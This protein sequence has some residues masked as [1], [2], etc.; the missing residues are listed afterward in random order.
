VE[1]CSLGYPRLAAFMS[2]ETTFGVYRGF[3]YLHSRLLLDRQQEV[4]ALETELDELDEIDAQEEEGR[5]LTNRNYDRKR[6]R[7]NEPGQSLRSRKAILDDIHKKVLE[8]DELLLKCREIQSFPKPSNRDYR[9]V[10]TWMF[11]HRKEMVEKDSSFIRAREDIITFRQGREWSSF[12]GFVE[13]T[14]M[15][16]DC[17]LIRVSTLFISTHSAELYANLSLIQKIFCTQ[18]LRDKTTDKFMFYYSSSRI[19][20]MVGL[21]MMV[22]VLV[23]L[24]IPVVVMYHLTNMDER[25]ETFDA[26]VVLIVFTLL[27]SAAMSLLT[28]A[29]RH[30]L[31]AATATYCAVLVVFISNFGG[32]SLS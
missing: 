5:R 15:R 30:E 11:N 6:P 27:F 9:S 13:S 17:S 23:L 24:A 28:K 14:L 18:E 16:F 31:F 12:D 21:L 32:K 19:E 3:G 26:I 25:N 2:S 8:Y 29:R 1:E 7:K 22:I 10:R 4:I 20:I